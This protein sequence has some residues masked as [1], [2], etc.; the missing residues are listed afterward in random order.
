MADGA[1]ISDFL[2]RAAVVAAIFAGARLPG[3]ARKRGT[4]WGRRRSAVVRQLWERWAR[5]RLVAA[6]IPRAVAESLSAARLV[7]VSVIQSGFHRL[8]RG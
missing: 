4:A 7:H 2:T 8:V 1:Q 5:S 6:P 3:L